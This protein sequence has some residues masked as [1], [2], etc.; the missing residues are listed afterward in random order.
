MTAKRAQIPGSGF[1]D[2]LA[3][4]R[5]GDA[6]AVA[7]LY[8]RHARRVMAIV[9][10]GLS[11]ALRAKYDT[12]DLAHSVFVEVL[13][14]LPRLEDRGEQA[15]ARLLAIKAENKVR[16]KLRRH[17]GDGGRRREIRLASEC[18]DSLPAADCAD[19]AAAERDDDAKLAGV[20]AGMDPTAR[21]IVRLRAEGASFADIAATTG[22]V[23]AEA[24]RKRHARA[25]VAL[26]RG[27]KRPEKG[28]PAWKQ[29]PTSS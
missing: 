6:D 8:E 24:A 19:A 4:A 20:L 14:E 18:D 12:L 5:A 15:F 13:R 7:S 22:L 21:T 29:R 28:A 11:P 23:G 3:R 25:L 27:W 26:R 2:V 17:L 1:S 16:T 10:R 9:R